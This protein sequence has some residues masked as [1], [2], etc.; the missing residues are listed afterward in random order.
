[1]CLKAKL[2]VGPGE[3]PWEGSVD[4]ECERGG[5]GGRRR[6]GKLKVWIGMVRRE[7]LRCTTVYRVHD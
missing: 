2:G 7:N 6:N 5:K 4:G 1:M 3:N